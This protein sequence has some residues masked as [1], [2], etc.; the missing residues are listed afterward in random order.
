MFSARGQMANVSGF[1]G[2][3]CVL[4]KLSPRQCKLHSDKSLFI[5][6]GGQQGRVPRFKT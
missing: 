5:K 6:A 2:T 4:Q 1:V 3:W